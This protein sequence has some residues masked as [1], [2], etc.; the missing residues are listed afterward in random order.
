[1]NYYDELPEGYKKIYHIDASNK[2]FVILANLI[3]VLLFIII[4]VV[5]FIIKKINFK[6][7]ISIKTSI[8]LFG[9]IV[10]LILYMILHELV[11]GLFYKIFTKKKLTFGIKLSCAF[12][13]VP[14]IYVKKWP[15]FITALAP[16][17]VFDIV[18]V[19]GIIF[20]DG[21]LCA[22]IVIMLGLHVGGCTGDLFI[23]LKMLTLKNTILINDIG[24]SQTIYD[25]E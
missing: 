8:Y 9:F 23:S 1:M 19:L 21:L 6:F 24:P 3:S 15:M 16:F 10:F 4:F 14:N 5:S 18:F 7:E 17:V 11:H 2:K 12:C 13:G 25:K 20:T 22:L